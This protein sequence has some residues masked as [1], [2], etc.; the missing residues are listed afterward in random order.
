MKY[1]LKTVIRR[2]KRQTHKRNIQRP[3]IHDLPFQVLK[4]EFHLLKS[5]EIYCRVED[6]ELP[7]VNNLALIVI[8][9]AREYAC[10]LVREH[11]ESSQNLRKNKKKRALMTPCVSSNYINKLYE[12][13]YPQY[14][15]KRF[16]K[17]S[18]QGDERKDNKRLRDTSFF[19]R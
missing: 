9:R 6:S 5:F 15:T 7:E 4:G 3:C 14:F 12:Y 8:Q 16:T 17:E 1:S 13:W 18:T 2:I 10:P 19:M 11:A